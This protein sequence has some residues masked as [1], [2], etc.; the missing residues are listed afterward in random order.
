[1]STYEASIG[2]LVEVYGENFP[3]R[4][5]GRALLAFQG[6]FEADDGSVHPIDQE[7]DATVVD[8]GTL[9][10]DSFGPY[11]VPFGPSG[12]QTGEFAGIVFVRTVDDD[13]NVT[14]IER[15][16]RK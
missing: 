7:F 11:R 13:G 1:M 15:T 6:N 2:T 3:T 16:V 10:W 4:S 14:I 12:N 9:R 5:E 8:R